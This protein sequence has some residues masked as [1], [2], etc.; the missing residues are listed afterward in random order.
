MSLIPP[1]VGPPPITATGQS[2]L[3]AAY[4]KTLV[5]MQSQLFD[6][7]ASYNNLIMVAGYA[8]TITI[9]G[10]LRERLPMRA[11]LLIALLLGVSLCIFIGY[12]IFKMARHVGHF[13]KVRELLQENLTPEAFF[14]KYNQIEYDSRHSL[15]KVGALASRICFWVTVVPAMLA[16]GLLFFNFARLLIGLAP[17]PADIG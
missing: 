9:W 11:N 5:E 4:R 13:Q 6:K 7:A 12:Q 16:L 17:L 1:N 15:L 3:A 10:N 2:E 14:E 8:G